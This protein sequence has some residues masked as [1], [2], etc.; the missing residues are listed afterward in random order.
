[1]PEN[2]RLILAVGLPRSGKSSWAHK[3][4]Q[5]YGYPIVCPDSIRMALYNQPYIVSAED[6]V[7]ASAR[8]MVRSLFL[9]GFDTVVLDSTG[10]KRSN[11][12]SWRKGNWKVL[13]QEFLTSEEDCINRAVLTDRFDLIPVIKRMA[14][15]YE[16]LDPDEV[17]Y[18][19]SLEVRIPSLDY[20]LRKIHEQEQ[21]IEDLKS[22]LNEKQSQV[23]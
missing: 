9:T 13:C 11:R 21:E 17:R 16:R 19:E 23:S 3:L 1:M 8:L 10:I 6:F 18:D 22:I 5:K 12:E 4:S 20:L 2:L 15:E 14:Q 7:W